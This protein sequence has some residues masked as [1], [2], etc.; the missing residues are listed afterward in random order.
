[1]YLIGSLEVSRYQASRVFCHTESDPSALL[2]VMCIG[3]SPKRTLHPLIF[4]ACKQEHINSKTMLSVHISGSLVISDYSTLCA[5][6]SFTC[7]QGSIL[8]YH[9]EAL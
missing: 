3:R 9:W 1:M 5:I 4:C 2:N 6:Y 7:I 8:D